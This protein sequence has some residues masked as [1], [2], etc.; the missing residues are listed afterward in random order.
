[1][2]RYFVLHILLLSSLPTAAQ[3]PGGLYSPAA[4]KADLHF[5][6]KQLEHNHPALYRYTS[7][8]TF[9]V[10][11]DSLDHLVQHPMKEQE[12]LSVLSLLNE[13][14]A[15]GHTMFLPSEAATAYNNT[16]GRFLPLSVS[17]KQGKLYIREN[18]SLNKSLQPGQ[19]IL[20]INDIPTDTLM[21]QLLKRQIRDGYNKTYPLWILQHYF[22]AYYSFAFGQPANFTLRIQGQAGEQEVAAL[23][24]DSIRLLRQPDTDTIDHVLY[25]VGQAAA[26]IV[27]SAIPHTRPVALLTIKTFDVDQLKE[28]YHQD[29]NTT[30][31]SIFALLQRSGYTDLVLDLR[32]NQ[33]GDF[34]PGRYLLSHLQRTPATYLYR[35]DEARLI[36]PSPR[37]FTGRL[38]VLMNGGTF[39]NAAIV[40][41]YL[42]KYAKALFI[43][44]E[45]GGNRHVISGKARGILLPNTHIRGYISTTNYLID[46]AENNGHGVQ[47]YYDIGG[48]VMG[49]KETRR[50]LQEVFLDAEP[51]PAH[52]SSAEML[53]TEKRLIG[54][55]PERLVGPGV[56]YGRDTAVY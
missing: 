40:S 32:D 12:F 15:D 52:Y 1:M 51:P 22:A 50:I 21:A 36:T 44:E 24:K 5:V 6:K 38:F 30:I 56:G 31:D 25:P 7:K 33:G 54:C 14:I 9:N 16:Q 29:F 23:T 28:Q 37:R 27:L 45:T 18:N 43:G 13:K 26:G 8:K 48:A 39:S 10:F 17:Y 20:A 34:E 3:V 47:P 2:F 11:L 42:E 19:E 35:G 41:A 46:R 49:P 55:I 53:K 4:L